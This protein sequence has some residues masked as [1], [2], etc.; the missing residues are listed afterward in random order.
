VDFK[1]LVRVPK[2]AAKWGFFW[3][4]AGYVGLEFFMFLRDVGGDVD[5]F[6][7]RGCGECPGLLG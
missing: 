7:L 3:D 6:A 4:Q 1:I 2:R 5:V